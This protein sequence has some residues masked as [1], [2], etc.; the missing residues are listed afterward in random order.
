MVALEGVGHFFCKLSKEKREG[1]QVFL[2]NAK[3]A[4]WLHPLPG[5]AEAVSREVG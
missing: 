1:P 3:P 4:Q 5:G 2:E